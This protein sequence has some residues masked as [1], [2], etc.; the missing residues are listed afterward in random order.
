MWTGAI[1]A[2]GHARRLGGL[3]KAGL[4]LR[5]GGASVLDRQLARLRR[6]VD[7]TI[8]IA[9]DAERF[10]G[11]AV[12]VIPDMVPGAGAIGALYTAVHA[13]GTEWTLVVA[14]DM[15]FI[16]ERL[17]AHLVSVGRSVD[18][19]IPMTARGYEPLCAT[20]SRRAAGELR[21]LIDERRFRLSDVARIPGLTVHEVGRDE[22]E[23]FGPEEVLF[24]N[25]NTPDD[26]ARAIDI[27]GEYHYLS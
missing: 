8:I 6:V 1:L 15:P 20:Y 7:R 25:L 18:I 3:N 9:N 2:G 17:L 19:A 21:R 22:L 23:T 26:Y 4:I 5:P 27:D 24:F 12:P 10:A 11:A 13:A 16:S 14:C